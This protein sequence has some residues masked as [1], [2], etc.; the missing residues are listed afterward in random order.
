[1]SARRG[2]LLVFSLLTIAMMVSAGAV[3]LIVLTFSPAAPAPIPDNATLYLKVQGPWSE[4]ESSD[5]FSQFVRRPR[6]LRATLAM[7]R[8]A[9]HDSRVK[10]LV[11]T[12][13]LTGVMWAQLQEVRDALVDFRE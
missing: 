12:P 1:M 8:R 6:T 5:V 2:V 4:I 3:L 13:Q 9:K 7:I 11:V 10:N